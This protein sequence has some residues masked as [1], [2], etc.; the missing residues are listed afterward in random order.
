M[1]RAG[2][3]KF[4]KK[5]NR[6]NILDIIREE[7]EVSR[8]FLIE[9][10]GLTAPTVSDITKDFL[11]GKLIQE[12]GAEESTGGRPSILFRLN[13]EARFTVGIDLE[14][15][16]ARA[17]LINFAGEEVFQI[18]RDFPWIES[19]EDLVE[20]LSTTSQ[21]LIKESGVDEKKLLGVGISVP[22]LVDTDNGYVHLFPSLHLKDIP[23]GQILRDK[24]SLDVYVINDA[25]AATIAEKWFGEAKNAE[26]FLCVVARTGIGAGF[27]LR[28]ELYR[29]P[30]GVAGEIGHQTVEIDGPLCDCGNYGC[31]ESF[32]G[33]RAIVKYAKSQLKQGRKSNILNMLDD[34]EK[35]DLETLI[36]AAGEKDAFALDIFKRVG[37]YLGIGI[38]NIINILNP[39]LVILSGDIL[40]YREYIESMHEILESKILKV[41][42]KACQITYSD[43]G[44]GIYSEGAGV[45]VLEQFDVAVK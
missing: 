27:Y 9:R 35:M 24:L 21:A 16:S 34:I 31:L 8:S 25:F 3:S 5:M 7:G 19:E 4:I 2:N 45:L 13:P 6:Q 26:D 10:T 17:S 40:K 22:G 14:E 44:A 41:Q 15:D 38:A 43:L 30:S 12:A 42:Q 29:G 20:I 33:R 36:Q 23:L 28:G 37:M 11:R 18:Q 39:E 1:V 32:A